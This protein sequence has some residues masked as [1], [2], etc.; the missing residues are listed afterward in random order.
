LVVGGSLGISDMAVADQGL[1][2]GDFLVLFATSSL[3]LPN[4]EKPQ[5]KHDLQRLILTYWLYESPISA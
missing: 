4:C 1:L 2:N 5:E 3:K